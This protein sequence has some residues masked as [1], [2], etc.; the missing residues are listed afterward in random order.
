MGKMQMRWPRK[1]DYLGIWGL[2]S[3]KSQHPYSKK[4]L[5][6]EKC[7]VSSLLQHQRKTNVLLCVPTSLFSAWLQLLSG[8]L[9]KGHA[10]PPRL[11]YE[12]CTRSFIQSTHTLAWNYTNGMQ[13]WFIFVQWIT[14]YQGCSHRSFLI[15][16]EVDY[17]TFISCIG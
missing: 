1:R 16:W 10:P 2:S 9:L 12:L 4:A 15:T 3:P 6:P 8:L 13:Y 17:N 7:A 11:I 5:E 14:D